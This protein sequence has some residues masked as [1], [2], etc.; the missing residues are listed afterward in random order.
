[1]MPTACKFLYMHIINDQP[2]VNDD[3]RFN[4]Y[5]YGHFPHGAP[6]NSWRHFCQN[7]IEDRFQEFIPDYSGAKRKSNEIPLSEIKDVPIAIF[8]G[9][10]DELADTIDA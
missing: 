2:E 1:M 10:N 5:G 4:V 6:A 3:D 9:M 8:A 7:A